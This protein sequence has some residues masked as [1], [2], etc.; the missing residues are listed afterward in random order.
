MRTLRR[1]NGAA[2]L[3]FAL[4]LPVL[5]IILSVILM[6]GRLWLVRSEILAVARQGARE[7]VL[8]P[9]AAAAASTATSAADT[10]AG[11]YRMDVSRLSVDPQGPYAPGAFYKVVVTYNVSL[12][13]I[14]DFGFLPGSVTLSATGLES[15]DP[16][17]TH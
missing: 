7:A 4:L 5:L 13:D 3:E 9:D 17:T 14:P 8:Q 10:A 1:D 12:G 6:A 15:I 11:D 2:A 16:E